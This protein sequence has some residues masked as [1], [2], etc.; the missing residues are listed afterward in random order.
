LG[1]DLLGP[2]LARESDSL[3][4]RDRSRSRIAI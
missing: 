3:I 4:D 1:E 2:R